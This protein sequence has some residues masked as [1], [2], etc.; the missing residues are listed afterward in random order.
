MSEAGGDTAS[1][2]PSRRWVRPVRWF[3]LSS[4]ATFVGLL[5]LAFTVDWFLG[6]AL[7]PSITTWPQT[8]ALLVV[9]LAPSTVM[10]GTALAVW[11]PGRAGRIVVGLL[12]AVNLVWAFGHIV[13]ERRPAPPIDR[14]VVVEIPDDDPQVG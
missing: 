7:G 13:E 8:F 4:A 2:G 12:V 10:L 11:G 9:L 1:S 3:L 5:H 6:P 14:D